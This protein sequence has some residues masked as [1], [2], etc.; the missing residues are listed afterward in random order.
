MN[1]VEVHM[2]LRRDLLMLVDLFDH[3]SHLVGPWIDGVLR[4][5]LMVEVDP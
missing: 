5:H 1:E 2:A 4:E 3:D